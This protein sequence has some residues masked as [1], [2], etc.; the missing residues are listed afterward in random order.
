MKKVVLL[1]VICIL[2]SSPGMAG[3]YTLQGFAQRPHCRSGNVTM[4]NESVVLELSQDGCH[5]EA[6]YVLSNDSNYTDFL[7]SGLP[8]SDADQYQDVVLKVDG[9]PYP[10]RQRKDGE[11]IIRDQGEYEY[12]QIIPVYWSLWEMEFSPGQRRTLAL[13]YTIPLDEL[14]TQRNPAT[15]QAVRDE[16]R[17]KKWSMTDHVAAVMQ[18][19]DFKIAGYGVLGRSNWKGGARI[20][21]HLPADAQRAC[22]FQRA[23]RSV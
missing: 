23:K 4:I 21:H 3:E 12:S 10:V 9:L 15:R 14:L 18:N 5:V 13:Q 22:R 2:M 11:Q 17:A 1:V 20:V 6:T 19:D 16:F 8:A 7:R